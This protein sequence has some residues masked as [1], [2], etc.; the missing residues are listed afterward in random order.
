VVELPPSYP[1]LNFRFDISDVFMTNYSF[2]G[3]R[4]FHRQRDSLDDDN[5]VNLKISQPSLS[6]MLINI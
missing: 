6:E 1:S 2:Y 4:H 3:M 5:F